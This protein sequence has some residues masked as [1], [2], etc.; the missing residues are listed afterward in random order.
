MPLKPFKGEN[1]YSEKRGRKFDKK[2]KNLATRWR[3]RKMIQLKLWYQSFKKILPFLSKTHFFSCISQGSDK[4]R[5]RN[6]KQIQKLSSG[7]RCLY[8]QLLGTIITSFCQHGN[9][10]I[11]SLRNYYNYWCQFI[12]TIFSILVSTTGLI[13]N[14]FNLSVKE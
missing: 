10:N 2:R 12:E 13:D 7:L 11:F 9:I 8:Y 3:R 1:K 6:Y 14:V 5:M 4:M